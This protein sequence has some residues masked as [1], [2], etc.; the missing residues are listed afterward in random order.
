MEMQILRSFCAESANESST[1]LDNFGKV[2]LNSLRFGG[3]SGLAVKVV[4]DFY[5]NQGGAPTIASLVLGIP[6]SQV[7]LLVFLEGL[8]NVIP[9]WGPNFTALVDQW[10]ERAGGEELRTLL[11]EAHQ[12]LTEGRTEKGKVSRGLGDAIGHLLSGCNR[13]QERKSPNKRLSSMQEGMQALYEDY[14]LKKSNPHLSY[15]VTTGIGPIDETTRGG[16][17]KEL[18]LVAGFTS[19]GK[20]TW[21]L[22]WAKNAAV[23]G[24]FNIFIYTFEMKEDAVWRMLA[25]I[26]SAHPKFGRTVPIKYDE[27]K[28]GAIASPEDEDQFLQE[29]LEDLRSGDHGHIHLE[30]PSENGT[31]MA[32]IRAKAEAINQ[33]FPLDMVLIDYLGLVAPD[34]GQKHA[35]RNEAINRNI[36]AAKVMATDFDRGSGVLVV[37]PHQINRQGHKEAQETGGVYTALALADANEAERSSDVIFAMYQDSAMEQQRESLITHIKSRDSKLILPFKVFYSKEHRLI[38]ELRGIDSDELSNLLSI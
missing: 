10:R 36:V 32:H 22:N 2:Q 13:I 16:Q 37:S 35:S 24:K 17:A 15:G 11:T 26:H 6:E 7:E 23:D 34:P 14:L 5:L 30:T 19:V 28:S 1:A 29:V 27:I 38:N 31:T 21:C 3:I 33:Q 12:V 8:K 20:S 25:C 18:W 4:S 9:L